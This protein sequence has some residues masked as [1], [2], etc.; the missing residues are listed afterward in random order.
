MSGIINAMPATREQFTHSCKR[1]IG[2]AMGEAFKAHLAAKVGKRTAVQSWT[3]EVD[4][5]LDL[6]LLTELDLPVKGFKDK[7]KALVQVLVED[8]APAVSNRIV[9]STNAFERKLKLK[10]APAQQLGVAD[11]R[12]FFEHVFAVVASSPIG[13]ISDADQDKILEIA[14]RAYRKG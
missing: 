4:R 13:A 3:R 7:R 2:G 10:L 14:F 1:F 11:V 12:M 5:L 9:S 8:I 6:E